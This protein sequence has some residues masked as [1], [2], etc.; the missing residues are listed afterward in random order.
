MRLAERAA[1]HF[2]IRLKP[3]QIEFDVSGSA[4][5]YYVRRQ[6]QCLIRYN[7]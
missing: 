7:P 6:Q 5:G 1:R 4:W 2:Q 3:L